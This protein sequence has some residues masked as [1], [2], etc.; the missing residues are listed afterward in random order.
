MNVRALVN[1]YNLLDK[2][3][4][5]EFR[6]LIENQNLTHG[7]VFGHLDGVELQIHEAL[8]Y[9]GVSEATFR[10]LIANGEIKASSTIGR[11]HLYA[12]ESLKRL[13]KARNA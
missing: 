8:A 6:A 9:L 5:N 3:A 7:E 1:E 13:K 11:S 12:L 2:N 10:R 4:Q